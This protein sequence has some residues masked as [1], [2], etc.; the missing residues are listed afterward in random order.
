M[1]NHKDAG[2]QVKLLV[3]TP[4]AYIGLVSIAME[5]QRSITVNCEHSTHSV[6]MV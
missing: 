3:S 4:S 6:V 1:V 5:S 2:H